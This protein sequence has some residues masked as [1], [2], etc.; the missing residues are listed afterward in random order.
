[1]TTLS[2]PS[3]HSDFL[4]MGKLILPDPGIYGLP[5]EVIQLALKVQQALDQLGK[6]DLRGKLQITTN[7]K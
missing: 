7:L 5:E 6:R 2:H 3:P 1:M 4:L